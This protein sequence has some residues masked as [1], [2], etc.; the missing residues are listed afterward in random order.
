MALK[1]LPDNQRQEARA[2]NLQLGVPG[3]KYADLNRV[4]RLEALDKAF[5]STLH[6]ADQVLARELL[7]YRND[8]GAGFDRL[9]ESELLI[10]VAQH[11]AAFVARLFR[12]EEEYAALCA[13]VRADQI[14][15][16]WKRQFVERRIF[17]NPPSAEAVA[18]MNPVELE[19]A[20]RGVV[21]ALMPDAALTADP[22]RELA[23]VT[24]TL[25]T[26]IDTSREAAARAAAQTQLAAVEAW[27]Q[28]LGFHPALAQ[29]R[30]QFTCFDV[31]HKVDHDDLVPRIRPRPDLPELFMGPPETRRHRDGFDLT[32][33][34][35]T[36]RENLREAHYCVTCHERGRDS[37]NVGFVTK[38]GAV[39]RNPL[40]IPLAGCPLHEKISEMIQLYRDGD[41]IGSL[42]VIMIDN[43]LLAGTGHRICNDC[44]KSCIFQKQ[45]P[46][47]IPQ[48]ETGVLTD[49][50][51]LPYGFEIVLALDPL[52]SAERAPP[53]S[54]ALQ[55]QERLGRRHGARRLH[56]GAPPAQRRIR[57][58]GHRGAE[59][60]ALGA[61]AAR[62]QTA[63]AAPDPRHRRDCRPALR[64][65]DARL[66]R[67]RR[68]RHHRALG[69]ELPRHQLHASSC[70]ARNSAYSTA[71]ASAARSRI[72]DAWS[73]GSIT[74]PSPP[75]P[76]GRP[77]SRM[78]NNLARGV[79]MAS[80]FLMA[81]Q[82]HGAYRGVP[83]EPA[84]R[85]PAVVDRRRP[86]RDR[87]GH[88][89]RRRTT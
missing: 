32:D 35:F 12:I 8:R 15:F 49:V 53:V 61:A 76:G 36:R 62:R 33:P 73:W 1:H 37:C 75:A 56:A 24:T 82:G 16:E 11:V 28:A 43:P 9:Q 48:I 27:V 65:P 34:R 60:G 17:K 78:Q 80:D 23:V 6:E 70:A 41:P 55:R 57:R 63:R 19:V 5:L 83:H 10:R 3:F 40:G 14:V 64:A 4:R 74:S 71:C 42:A 2:W 22:E 81:L 7:R 79:R 77:S 31:P 38:D 44:M 46:V 21:D 86:D 13:R 59:G 26:I 25:Q 88:R 69:Q 72:D 66:R 67:R 20:Y 87:H 85:L 50:L 47:N 51:R 54:A 58:G 18:Q 30:R 45:E 68:V 89:A 39:Q 52:E 29:R 84:G